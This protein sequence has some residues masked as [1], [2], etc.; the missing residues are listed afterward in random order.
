MFINGRIELM[1]LKLKKE[2]TYHGLK[3]A[4]SLTIG[5]SSPGSAT[6]VFTST[7]VHLPVFFYLEND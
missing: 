4:S 6:P 1:D 3:A 7:P 2:R 5:L